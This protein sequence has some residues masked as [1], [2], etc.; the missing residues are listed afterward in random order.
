MSEDLQLI[1]QNCVPYRRKKL[2]LALTLPILAVYGGV[3]AALFPLGFEYLLIYLVLLLL[4][5]VLQSFICV[6]WDC[7]YVGRFAPCVAGF[8]LPASQ[9][10]RLWKKD[11]LPEKFYP[12]VLNLTFLFFLGAVFFP[13][14]F[15]FQI[16]V[17]WG[18][19]YLAAAGL[20]AA[21]FLRWICPD[22]ATRNICPGGQ[23]AVRLQEKR[24]AQ[25]K[26]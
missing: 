9:L 12:L 2:Y 24:S 8:C 20:Y 13:L 18:I 25:I 1:D 17:I 14:Y 10:A 7:P 26:G 22:C 4:T 6:Y 3:A 16:G 15:L 11:S 23:L 21:G 19:S 5:S